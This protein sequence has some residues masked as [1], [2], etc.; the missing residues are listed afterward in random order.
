LRTIKRNHNNSARRPQIS[1][2]RKMQNYP[3]KVSNNSKKVRN[4]WNRLIIIKNSNNL[5]DLSANETVMKSRIP[6]LKD[7][8]FQQRDSLLPP[9]VSGIL[10]I[11]YCYQKMNLT[12]H[13]LLYPPE[14]DLSCLFLTPKLQISIFLT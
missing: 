1:Y 4:Y 3:R 8:Q 11:E 7:L 5:R 14:M 10:E 13:R 6:S 2:Q 9:L 12:W